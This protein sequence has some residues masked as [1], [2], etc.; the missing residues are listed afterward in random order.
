VD[1]EAGLLAVA[2]AVRSTG[3]GD[4]DGECARGRIG[5]CVEVDVGEAAVEADGLV[6]Q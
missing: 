3:P 1:R 2:G 5:D 6:R 4:A